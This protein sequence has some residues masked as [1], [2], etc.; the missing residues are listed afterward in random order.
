MFPERETTSGKGNAA[1]DLTL[2][3][4]GDPADLTE[5]VASGGNKLTVLRRVAALLEARSKDLF[6]L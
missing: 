3:N 6:S 5:Q 1:W 4:L 2:L